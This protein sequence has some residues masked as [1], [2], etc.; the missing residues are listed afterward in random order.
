MK[1]RKGRYM[2]E[3]VSA[4]EIRAARNAYQRAWNAKNRDKI[5]EYNTRYWARRAAQEEGENK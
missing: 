3:S 4:D 5:R 1:A 2:L